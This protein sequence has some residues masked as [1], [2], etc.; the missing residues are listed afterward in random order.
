MFQE[1]G[2]GTFILLAKIIQKL[3]GPGVISCDIGFLFPF[4]ADC[5]RGSRS[6]SEQ[7]LSDCSEN[8]YYKLNL[9]L[10]CLGQHCPMECSVMR[11]L[12]CESVLSNMAATRHL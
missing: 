7:V 1:T 9:E 4:L 12:F 3:C 8:H 10:D 2:R 5:G 11:K 6:S